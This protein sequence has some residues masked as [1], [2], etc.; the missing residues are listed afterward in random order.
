MKM[1]L[2]HMSLTVQNMY[3]ELR[4]GSKKAVMVVRNNMAYSEPLWKKTPVA[5]AIAALPVP[6][7]PEEVQL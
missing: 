7:P 2:C 5:G 3:T 6:K 1:A 4:E